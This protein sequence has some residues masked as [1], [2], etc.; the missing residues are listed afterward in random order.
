VSLLDA[1]LRHRVP[2]VREVEELRG[3][4]QPGTATVVTRIEIREEK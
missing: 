3:V 1:V 4:L 2:W